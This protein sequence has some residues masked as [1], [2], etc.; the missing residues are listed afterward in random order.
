MCA[1]ALV[2][3]EEKDTF[4][5]PLFKELFAK[6]PSGFPR[7]NSYGRDR[8][9]RRHREFSMEM[10]RLVPQRATEARF[11]CYLYPLSPSDGRWNPTRRRVAYCP[12][13]KRTVQ[14][15][16]NINRPYRTCVSA[17]HA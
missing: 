2:V 15:R 13:P 9:V 10:R 8:T 3:E 14:G 11:R 7:I 12:R 16:I 4:P 17:I 5:I 1:N 6:L